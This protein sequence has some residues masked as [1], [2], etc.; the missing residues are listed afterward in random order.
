MNKDKP[1][2]ILVVSLQGIGDLL[3]LTPFLH[4]L[5]KGIPVDKISVLTFSSNKDILSGN[6]DV[7]EIIAF[8]PRESNNFL[9]II[10]LLGCLR[11]NSYDISICAYPSGLRSAFIAFA[12]G[13]KERLGQ[14]LGIFWRCRWLFTKQTEIKEVK[15][16][17]LMNMDF[18]YLLGVGTVGQ[19][20]AMVLNVSG[21]EKE[22]A[23]DFLKSEGVKNGD[24]LIAV[25]AGGGKFTAAYRNWPIERFSKVADTLIEGSGAKVVFIGGADDKGAV[26]KAIAYM[27]NKAIVAAGKLSLKETAALIGQARLLIC[28]NSG[29]MHM[30]A[31]L[32]I[33]TVSIFGSADP[34]IHRPWGDGHVVLQKELDCSPCYYPFF[35][36]TLKE[37]KLR[38]RWFGKKFECMTGDYRC[39][40]SITVEE[41]VAAA[42]KILEQ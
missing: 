23:F 13:A 33:P 34:R 24:L 5:K 32:G 2:N 15:H 12:C 28:N 38:N 10:G 1:K 9:S 29:P 39:L 7:D 11:G 21:E 3:L 40:G 20:N 35:R 22:R 18:L 17:V 25:H 6:P 36:D 8:N 37:T 19:D 42:K 27:E 41:V 30:A 14:D 16:A 31:A 26:D 4:A